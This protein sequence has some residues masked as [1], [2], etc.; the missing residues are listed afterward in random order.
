ME[1]NKLVT[2]TESL[3]LHFALRKDTDI[4]LKQKN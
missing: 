4:N 2:T 3:V 1:Y